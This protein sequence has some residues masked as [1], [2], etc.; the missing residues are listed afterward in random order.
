[1]NFAPYDLER[2]LSLTSNSSSG[3]SSVGALTP[4]LMS[5]PAF[6]QSFDPPVGL[7]ESRTVKQAL[8][9]AGSRSSEPLLGG[10]AKRGSIGDLA[11]L[12]RDTSLLSSAPAARW[13][14]G[15]RAGSASV[16]STRLSGAPGRAGKGLGLVIEEGENRPASGRASPI[17]TSWNT[18]SQGRSSP[19]PRLFPSPSFSRGSV[20]S[21]T[22]VAGAMSFPR[23]GSPERIPSPTRDSL[24]RH[25]SL[26]GAG[27]SH[28]RTQT[29]PSSTLGALGLPIV[30][31]EEIPG[32]SLLR[33]V[34][35]LN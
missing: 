15:H 5:S 13:T 21:P 31:V 4:S 24:A 35:G 22:R 29:L 14:A 6:T 7:R 11:S 1:M 28:R 18:A 8:A 10:A 27:G 20:E 23:T 30:G 19:T 9:S 32:P 16:D 2:S 17:A 3:S 25:G 12:T 33:H 26:M 34:D